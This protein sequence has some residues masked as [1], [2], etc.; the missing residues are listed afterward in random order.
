[1]IGPYRWLFIIVRAR[2][3]LFIY[4]RNFVLCIVGCV[5]RQKLLWM[6]HRGQDRFPFSIP[7]F[8]PCSIALYQHVTCAA[9]AVLLAFNG[10]TALSVCGAG[11]IGF[12]ESTSSH[13]EQN[14]AQSL[15]H[16]A[17]TVLL[18]Q[19]LL[20]KCSDEGAALSRFP[21]H[22]PSPQATADENSW[23]DRQSTARVLA[24]T[25]QGF[26]TGPRTHDGSA[27]TSCGY[28][29]PAGCQKSVTAEGGQSRRRGAGAG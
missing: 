13:A 29:Q 3:R 8:L 1:M 25:D 14:G 19:S 18:A 11:H 15:L 4:L 2:P 17:T 16:G 5:P 6:E 9:A 24:S 23:R 12:S 10:S 22:L 26:C 21:A 27:S 7:H 28:P 20:P